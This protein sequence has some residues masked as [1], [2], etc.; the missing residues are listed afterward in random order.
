MVLPRLIHPVQCV[1]KI[2]NRSATRMD[3]DTREPLQRLKYRGQITLSGQ[4][5][6]QSGDS[7]RKKSVD[8]ERGG[9]SEKESG[10]ILFRTVDLDTALKTI[11]STY[12]EW[13]NDYNGAV[14]DRILSFGNQRVNAFVTRLEPIGH[15]ADQGGSS[16]V[17]VYFTD[18]SSARKTGGG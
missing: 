14:N 7:F 17:K 3:S 2:N 18:R 1:L 12:D 10:Y 6:G 4:P 15:Y 5:S 8:M 9:R 11:G 16:L 13:A